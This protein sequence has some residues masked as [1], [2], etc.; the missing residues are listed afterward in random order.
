MDVYMF[1]LD[2]VAVR[3]PDGYSIR[4]HFGDGIISK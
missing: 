2:F 3:V 4:I 1:S